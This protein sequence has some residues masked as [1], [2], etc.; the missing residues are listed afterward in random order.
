MCVIVWM[1]ACVVICLIIAA[2]AGPPA[3]GSQSE[4]EGGLP[5]EFGD[6]VQAAVAALDR[7]E[8]YRSSDSG[9]LA[10]RESNVLEAFYRMYEATHDTVWLDR[11]VRRADVIFANRS[12]GDLGYPGWRTSAFS[13]GLVTAKAAAGNPS[14]ATIKTDP[15]RTYDVNRFREVTGHDYEIDFRAASGAGCSFVVRDMTV[16]PRSKEIAAAELPVDGRIEQV[17]GVVLFI[18]G[19]PQPGDRFFVHTEVPRADEYLCHDGMILTPVARFCAAVLAPPPLEAQY[20]PTPSLEA[21]Y[22]AIARR[23]VAIMETEVVPKW[24]PY[25]RDLPSGGGV[26]LRQDHPAARA[27]GC[28]QPYNQV[29]AFG[30]MQIALYRI[31]GK[32]VYRARVERMARWF[33][34]GLRPIAT[35]YEWN[36]WDYVRAGDEYFRFACFVEDTG[37]GHIDVG[38][39]IDAYDAGIVF[40]REDMDRFARTITES[41]WNGSE[42]KPLLGNRVNTSEGGSLHVLDWVQY[43]RFSPKVRQIMGRMLES[44]EL[45][46]GQC[47]AAAQ[48]LALERLGWDP[49]PYWHTG[50]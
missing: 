4:A 13:T 33:K 35:H 50:T 14:Q 27:P 34:H 22:G 2:T 49:R 48:A 38:S 37:H 45:E 17:P 28:S 29:L 41:M 19:T 5:A 24:E 3:E 1:S 10:W 6:R 44:L 47:A 8:G 46:G 7:D 39:V 11:I 31:T 18:E 40:D 36:Y 26:Y 9:A 23:Y 30:R 12:V 21:Q 42:E 32:P 15:A 43:G 20:G 25:W 16:S